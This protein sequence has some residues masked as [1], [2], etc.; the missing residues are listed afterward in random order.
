M[1]YM[2]KCPR[3]HGATR[4]HANESAKFVL[5]ETAR[6]MVTVKPYQLQFAQYAIAFVIALAAGGSHWSQAPLMS[7][8]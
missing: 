3:H 4:L 2:L 7:Y 1:A 5:E 6:D 8:M